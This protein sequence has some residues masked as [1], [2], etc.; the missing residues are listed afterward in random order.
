LYLF[1]S[2]QIGNRYEQAILNILGKRVGLNGRGQGL[3]DYGGRV[4][5]ITKGTNATA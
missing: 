1:V 3:Y 5:A 4:K 2:T